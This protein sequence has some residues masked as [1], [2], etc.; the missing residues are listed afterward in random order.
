MIYSRHNNHHNR[1]HNHSDDGYGGP[2][3]WQDSYGRNS[4]HICAGFVNIM[5]LPRSS[6]ITLTHHAHP[7]RSPITLT[8]HAH[9]KSNQRAQG[10][11]LAQA[12]KVIFEYLLERDENGAVTSSD[13]AGW[14]PLH[15]ASYWNKSAIV[16]LILLKNVDVNQVIARPHV[17]DN[18]FEDQDGEDDEANQTPLHKAAAQGNWAVVLALLHAGANPNLKD[19]MGYTPLTCAMRGRRRL[20]PKDITYERQ[21]SEAELARP[22]LVAQNSDGSELKN[23]TNSNQTL[24]SPG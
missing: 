3:L 10:Q 5:I 23:M 14:T 19:K 2:L 1:N 8:H 7:S 11:H 20:N 13:N 24:H 15:Y 9:I 21:Y 17:L 4:L 16:S 22:D 6:P 12:H 18:A